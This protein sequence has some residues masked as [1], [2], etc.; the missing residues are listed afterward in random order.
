VT[1]DARGDERRLPGEVGA[2]RVDTA[3][4]RATLPDDAWPDG[5]PNGT[6]WRRDAFDVADR[7]RDG[8]ATGR[9]LLAAALMW[10]YGRIGYGRW[11]AAGTFATPD[12]DARLATALAPLRDPAPDREALRASYV[13]FRD[14]GVARLRRLGPAFFTKVIYFAGYRRGVGGVQPLILDA[15]VARNLPAGLGIPFGRRGGFWR[16]AAWLTYLDWPPSRRARTRSETN[17]SAWRWRC[18][19]RPGPRRAPRASRARTNAPR[20][21]RSTASRGLAAGS[22]SRA[23]GDA[24][25]GVHDGSRPVERDVS[26]PRASTAG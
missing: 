26:R 9:Q 20:T 5:F 2:I 24:P 1:R 14:P 11:R 15:R 22:R 18:S 16:S 21:R 17:P 12:L 10:G 25:R 4:W 13:A 6:V 3:A 8:D 19:P 7:R 23:T